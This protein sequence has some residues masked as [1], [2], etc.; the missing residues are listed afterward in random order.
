M[1]RTISK[2]GFLG[3]CFSGGQPIKGVELGPKAI[4]E[5]GVFK[6]LEANYGV[7]TIDYGDVN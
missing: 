2:L 1:R 5:S 4:R 6:A 3:A 7:K